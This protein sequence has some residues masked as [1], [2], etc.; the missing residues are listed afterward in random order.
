MQRSEVNCSRSPQTSGAGART[1]VEV[2][3]AKAWPPYCLCHLGLWW[4]WCRRDT[5]AAHSLLCLS[6]S[7]ISSCQETMIHIHDGRS[8]SLPLILCPDPHQ[9]RKAE[10]VLGKWGGRRGRDGGAEERAKARECFY[11]FVRR[12]VLFNKGKFVDLL[13]VFPLRL[14]EGGHGSSFPPE[15][16]RT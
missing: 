15:S 11:P 5:R 3:K 10:R 6:G 14:D 7:S 13:G 1:P 2:A 4:L 9:S 8:S 16:F 12:G